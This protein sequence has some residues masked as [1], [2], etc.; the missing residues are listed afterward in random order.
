M[1]EP[2]SS[3]GVAQMGDLSATSWQHCLFSIVAV[4]SLSLAQSLWRILSAPQGLSRWRDLSA[5]S[6]SA[7]FFW[8]GNLKKVIFSYQ[9][10]NFIFSHLAHRLGR[11]LSAPQGLPRWGHL[12]AHPGSSVNS[13]SEL[14]LVSLICSPFFN[15]LAHRLGG[16]S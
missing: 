5:Q 9:L 15:S 7:V 1:E 6:G 11:N 10:D 3:T 16:T 8:G 13:R 4:C 2:F 12:S 14:I